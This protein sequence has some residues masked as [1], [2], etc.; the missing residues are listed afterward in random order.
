MCENKIKCDN[1]SR[2]SCLDRAS[3]VSKH[4]YIIPTD[5]HNYKITGMLK[6]IKIPTI[7][8]TCFDSRRNHNQG[9]ISSL[10]K[11]TI[12]ILLCSSLMTWSV[13]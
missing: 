1:Y 11:T 4:F 3:M 5:A 13:L 8:P 12:M 9:A 6:T 7:A 2:S 10:A